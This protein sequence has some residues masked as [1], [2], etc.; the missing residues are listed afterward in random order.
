MK[1]KRTASQDWVRQ[2][3]KLAEDQA[4]L[5]GIGFEEPFES[6]SSLDELRLKALI[7]RKSEEEEK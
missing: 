2:A 4:E 7:I 6:C 1:A 5:D 3:V